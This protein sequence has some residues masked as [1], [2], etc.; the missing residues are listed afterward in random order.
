MIFHSNHYHSSAMKPV[1][2]GYLWE[3]F[4]TG[5]VMNL[6]LFSINSWINNCLHSVQLHPCLIAGAV[7]LAYKPVFIMHLSNPVVNRPSPHPEA[8]RR[9]F[10]ALGMGGGDNLTERIINGGIHNNEI[11]R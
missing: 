6:I 11:H 10:V 2:I 3:C 1:L 4:N 9:D 7:S 8:Y 5:Y